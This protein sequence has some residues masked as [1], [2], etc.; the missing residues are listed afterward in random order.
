MKYF[1]LYFTVVVSV[2]LGSCKSGSGSDGTGNSIYSA[3]FYFKQMTELKLDVVYESGAEP[4]VGTSGAGLNYWDVTLQN[5]QALFTG[6][7]VT[8]SIPKT[9]PE[10]RQ[11]TSQNR[12]VWSSTDVLNLANQYRDGDS[13]G[14]A[15]KIFIAFVKGYA[16]KS[17]GT[18]DN[19]VIGFSVTG[20][21]VIII[22]KQVVQASG[23][24]PTGPVPKFVE[25]STI[26]HELAHAIGFVNNGVTLTSDHHD[27]A[28]GAHCSNPSCVMYY[29][30][31]GPSDLAAFIDKYQTSQNAVMFDN[32]CLNDAK[33]F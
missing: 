25:Q 13:S 26:V 24:S 1:A 19:Q 22:F 30:N 8:F 16:A 4:F 32:A 10:M 15:G 12:S 2:L 27:S 23:V 29:L 17:D 11:I 5:L 7:N 18:A 3:T 20:T 28:H 33:S 14:T 31:E 9:L 21:N 6:R